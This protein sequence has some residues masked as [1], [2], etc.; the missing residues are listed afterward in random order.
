MQQPH[1][2]L[3][4]VPLCIHQESPLARRQHSLHEL[5]WTHLALEVAAVPHFARQLSKALHHQALVPRVSGFLCQEEVPHRGHAHKCL[6]HDVDVVGGLEVVEAHGAREVVRAVQPA[7]PVAL[8]VQL[9]HLLR[10]EGRVEHVADVVQRSINHLVPFRQTVHLGR[11]EVHEH[12]VRRLQAVRVRL[13]VGPAALEIFAARQARVDVVRGE[14]YGAA[15]LEV[16]VQ[17]R[18]A[19]GVEVRAVAAGAAGTLAALSSAAGLRRVLAVP[20]LL[21]ELFG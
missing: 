12:V 21:R 13:G 3:H 6:Q 18:S 8:G 2:K 7:R 16:E 14:S 5:V 19:D 11:L 10:R 1:Q 20:V 17:Q 4:G 15:L 9:A